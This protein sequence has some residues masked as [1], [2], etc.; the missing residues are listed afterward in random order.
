[1]GGLAI[2]GLFVVLTVIAVKKTR[3][4]RTRP[5]TPVSPA[6]AYENA[7]PMYPH[8]LPPPYSALSTPSKDKLYPD[9]EKWTENE[10][11]VAHPDAKKAPRSTGSKS[12]SFLHV[13]RF[14]WQYILNP[15]ALRMA[16]TLWSFGHSECKR[17]KIYE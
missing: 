1:M 13:T 2:I 3:G 4:N 15:N 14:L 17:I 10:L 8:A 12:Y 16:K 6:P 9:V 7:R 11:K 5:N